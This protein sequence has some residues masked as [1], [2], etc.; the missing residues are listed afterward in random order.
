VPKSSNL[1]K[2]LVHHLVHGEKD[3]EDQLYHHLNNLDEAQNDK[4]D[5]T[6]Y[7]TAV[8]EFVQYISANYYFFKVFA[9]E[10]TKA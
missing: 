2:K 6:R 3:F 9:D 10:T 4:I 7:P 1:F 5:I 8:L